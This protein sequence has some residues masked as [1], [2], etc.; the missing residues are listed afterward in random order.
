MDEVYALGDRVT[1][2]ARRR[3]GGSLDKPQIRADTICSADVGREVSSFYKKEHDPQARLGPPV[4]A[5]VDITDGRRVKGCSLTVHAGEVVGL[6]GLFG[7]GR[8]GL[9][10][11]IIGASP[12]PPAMSNS[13]PCG[14][15]THAWRGSPMRALPILPKTGGARLFLTCLSGQH[16]PRQ[17]WAGREARLH[18]D[19]RQGPRPCQ[20][21][22]RG[23]GHSRR[24][25]RVTAAWNLWRQPAEGAAVAPACNHPKVPDSRRPTRGVD[26]GAKSEI[27]SIID[28]LA[29]SG[30]A[31]LVIS[32]DL[33][34]VI[35]SATAS[36]SCVPD[37]SPAR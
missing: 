23:A 36:L 34:E 31:I 5:A 15:H 3:A 16:Q 33:P 10:H 24:G 30:T 32:S 9:A 28:N 26:V 11:L 7:A 6:A 20:Q 27:Y 2:S 8:T 25:C 4:L 19:R 35:A 14:H 22:L 37:V 21:G 29:K 12:R 17:C 18:A 13:K 1:V